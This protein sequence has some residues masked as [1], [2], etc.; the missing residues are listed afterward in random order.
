M[1]QAQA[2][3]DVTVNGV[4]NIAYGFVDQDNDGFQ[5]QAIN[6][7]FEVFF[8]IVQTLENGITV[9]GRVELEGFESGDQIDERWIYFRG[10][11]GEIRVGDEDDAR[12]LLSYTAP[13][14]TNFLFGVNSPSF[15][16]QSLATGQVVSSNS[17]TPFDGDSS[18][19]IYFTPSFGGFQLAASYA[20]DAS[21]DRTGFGTGSTQDF[22]S[23]YVSIGASYSGEFDGFTIGAGGG[24]SQAHAET[25]G[26]GPFGNPINDDSPYTWAAGANIGFGGFT[27]GG[28]I[29]MGD[30][31][32]STGYNGYSVT[33]ATV[34][35][36]GVTYA[37]EAVTVGIAWSHGTYEDVNDGEDDEL[38]FVDLGAGY[39]IGEGVLLAAFVGWFDYQ[40]GG[41][42]S[43]DNT[44]WQAGIGAGLDF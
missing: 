11:F 9:G 8:Q 36:I 34:Y 43:N 21:Q 33:E 5:N 24:Y 17:T 44:G 10:G 15:T 41:P 4:W 29:A 14:P 40:D 39:T 28:S 3:F 12:K 18:K 26:P 22:V 31:L 6:E 25:N 30:G 35:D 7:D 38:D 37:F 1:G 27:V 13:N 2:K 16:F 19:I 23:S 20:P 42:T 32:D